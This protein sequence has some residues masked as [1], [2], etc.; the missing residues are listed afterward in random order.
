M[1]SLPGDQKIK[2]NSSAAQT[3]VIK[4]DQRSDFEVRKQEL[5]DDDRDSISTRNHAKDKDG[6]NNLRNRRSLAEN[7]VELI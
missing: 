6:N 4:N 2:M 1:L 3:N 7:D 5:F